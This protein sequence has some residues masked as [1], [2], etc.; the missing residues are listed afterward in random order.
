[1]LEYL[2]CRLAICRQIVQANSLLCKFK[3][4]W[5][6]SDLYLQLFGTY[7]VQFFSHSLQDVKPINH[8][9]VCGSGKCCTS[10]SLLQLGDYFGINAFSRS[11]LYF[12]FGY[13]VDFFLLMVYI[14]ARMMVTTI[15]ICLAY[16]RSLQSHYT[17]RGLRNF[18]PLHF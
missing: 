10:C 3:S 16:C 1:M 4:L 13:S 2:F 6:K 17:Y 5:Y 15:D 9:K 7:F 8:Q 11:L 12:T 18:L 14:L